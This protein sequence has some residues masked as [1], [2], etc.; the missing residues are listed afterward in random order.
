MKM[1]KL[2]GKIEKLDT[3][4]TL[5]MRW[6]YGL[7]IFPTSMDLTVRSLP[8]SVDLHNFGSSFP[9]IVFPIS[10]RLFQLEFEH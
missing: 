6:Y 3:L 5:E 4:G 7:R 2:V 9:T 10:F 1:I 8:T